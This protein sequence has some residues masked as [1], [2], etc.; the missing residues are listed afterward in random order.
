MF[1]LRAWTCTH[2]KSDVYKFDIKFLRLNLRADQ[3]NKKEAST[4]I[5]DTFKGPNST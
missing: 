5:L 4:N 3:M 2:V 1:Q